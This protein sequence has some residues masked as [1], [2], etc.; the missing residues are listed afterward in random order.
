MQRRR[1]LPLLA[2]LL[3]ALPAAA[4][5]HTMGDDPG[6]VRWNSI[7][8]P[9]Y[10]VIYPRGLDSLGRAYA[11]ALERAAGPVGATVGARPNAA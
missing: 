9:T 7:E 11:I 4:Q 8:T 6:S 2:A 10:R 1:F 5:F 3:T